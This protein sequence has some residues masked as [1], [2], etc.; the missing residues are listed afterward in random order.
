MLFALFLAISVSQDQAPLRAGCSSD[1]AI[2]ATLAAGTTL[3]LKYAMS[4][5][6]TPCYKVSAQVDGK[7]IDGY[8]PGD[9]ID[10]LATFDKARREANWTEVRPSLPAPKTPAAAEEA[11]GS[12]RVGSRS[13]LVVQANALIEKGKPEEALRLLEPALRDHPDAGLLTIAGIAE[14]K[15]EDPKQ[16]LQYWRQSLDMTPDPDLQKL[17]ARVERET[18][19]DKS[20]EKLYGY[21]VLLRY[22][23][24]TVPVET[25]RTMVKVVDDAY[26]RVSAQLGCT[27]DDRIVTIVQSWDAY[28]KTTGAAEWSA[29]SFDG[30]IHL[31]VGAG[32]SVNA[33]TEKRLAHETTHACL[34]MLGKWPT[35]LHEGMA[36]K[37][38]GEA[39]SP[40]ARARVADAIKAGKMPPLESLDHGWMN[41]D[42][43]NP[44]LA[45]SAA[46][47]AVERLYADYGADGVRNLLK[48]PERLEPITKDLD[49]KLGL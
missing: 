37:L 20:G 21:R 24:V 42:P 36:Q 8:L 16:A 32:Q 30:R 13:P 3:T 1:S 26:A 22:D 46:L 27:T 31:P 48:N 6:S 11:S 12:I 28:Y 49:Q 44:G 19:N 23:D 2:R 47:A 41:A 17:Y 29:G 34:A 4:G 33:E 9:A 38:S 40:A 15:N 7:Q 5:E 14:W 25:A 39:L 18:Q 43:H 35:W 10:G 45:Y